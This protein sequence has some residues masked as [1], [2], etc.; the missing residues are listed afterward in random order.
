MKNSLEEAFQVMGSKEKG[1]R[2]EGQRKVLHPIESAGNKLK[3]VQRA[4]GRRS[5]LRSLALGG[6]LGSTW[7]YMCACVQCREWHARV[8][9]VICMVCVHTCIC[10]V[11]GAHDMY[12]CMNV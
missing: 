6:N 7:R 3:K 9:G 8:V 5:L 11:R 10:V 12:A 4:A 2:A 1:H